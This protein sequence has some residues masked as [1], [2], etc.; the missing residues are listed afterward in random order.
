MIMNFQKASRSDNPPA[1]YPFALPDAENSIEQEL[2][3]VLQ[4]HQSLIP[5]ITVYYA[6]EANE[7]HND[8]NKTIFFAGAFE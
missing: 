6:V 2:S 7:S 3:Q 5:F 8:G 4:F 1:Q